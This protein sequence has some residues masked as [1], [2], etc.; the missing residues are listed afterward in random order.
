MSHQVSTGQ[1]C[2][3]AITETLDVA[4]ELASLRAA[5]GAERVN[6]AELVIFG[7]RMKAESVR[8][9]DNE[10]AAAIDDLAE[11]VRSGSRT[12]GCCHVAANLRAHDS[13]PALVT[14]LC[15]SPSQFR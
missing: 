3:H 14:P 5:T 11:M 1:T 8:A 7:A 9:A 13:S 4:S 12:V 2:R 10:R 15:S 6:L